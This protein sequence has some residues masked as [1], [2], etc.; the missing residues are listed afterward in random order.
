MRTLLLKH[1][2]HILKEQQYCH[3][4]VGYNS[5]FESP[6]RGKDGCTGRGEIEREL[7]FAHF[8]PSDRPGQLPALQLHTAISSALLPLSYPEPLFFMLENSQKD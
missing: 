8:L 2:R 4:L 7:G 6:L 1:Q 5:K 3:A